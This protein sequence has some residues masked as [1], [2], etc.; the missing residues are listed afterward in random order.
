LFRTK[1]KGLVEYG[2]LAQRYVREFDCKW[3]RGRASDE[4]LLGSADVQ[5]LADLANGFEVISGMRL[6]AVDR[7]TVLALALAIVLPMVP[8]IFTVFSPSEVIAL[9]WKGIF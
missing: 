5:S 6:V 9:L 4:A 1:H 2:T 3:V 7:R 8:L